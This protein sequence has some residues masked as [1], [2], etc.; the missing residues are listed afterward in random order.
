MT[1]VAN[2]IEKIEQEIQQLEGKLTDLHKRRAELAGHEA[3]LMP[4]RKP[5]ERWFEAPAEEERVRAFLEALGEQ[6]ANQEQIARATGVPHE[7][8]ARHLT[9]DFVEKAGDDH[10]R[11]QNLSGRY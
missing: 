7:S 10:Y 2:Q 6:G 11:M 3:E 8:L 9:K 1:N 4:D 5:G